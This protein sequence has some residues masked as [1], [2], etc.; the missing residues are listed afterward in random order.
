MLCKIESNYP[1]EIDDMTFFQDNNL[2]NIEIINQYENLISQGEYN[3]ANNYIDQQVGVYGYFADFFNVIENKLYNLQGHLLT[4]E[5]KQPFLFYDE[6]DSYPIDSLHIFYEKEDE[7]GTNIRLS[8]DIHDSLSMYA[9]DELSNLISEYE[10][11]LNTIV[12][13]T[14][15]EEQESIDGIC[16]FTGE[17]KEPPNTN[18]NTIWI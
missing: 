8:R 4:K 17:E 1:S 3:E 14:D 2:E 12:L 16:M 15:N 18:N 5:K 6:E 10:E 13:F 7:L 11:G 9:H